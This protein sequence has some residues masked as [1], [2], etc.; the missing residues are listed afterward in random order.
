MVGEVPSYPSKFGLYSKG[1]SEK[2]QLGI[3][4]LIFITARFSPFD[5]DFDL[6]D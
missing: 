6:F 5:L 4:F 2:N 1:T 3:H